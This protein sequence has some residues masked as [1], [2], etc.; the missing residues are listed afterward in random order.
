MSFQVIS[1]VK[2]LLAAQ[3]DA[4]S[5]YFTWILKGFS[6]ITLLPDSLQQHIIKTIAEIYTALLSSE[7]ALIKQK[8]L[9]NFYD[10]SHLTSHAEIIAL[11][12]QNC[13][14]LK[15]DVTNYFQ[16]KIREEANES[17]IEQLCLMHKSNF[18]HA[19]H[20]SNAPEK[21]ELNKGSNFSGQNLSLI[22]TNYQEIIE[23]WKEYSENISKIAQE[24]TSLQKRE[25]QD[26]CTTL[27][28]ILQ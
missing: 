25:I 14:S 8:A 15:Q 3:S 26:F 9:E 6:T 10:F 12:V 7:K 24:L 23:R 27:L 19:C 5:L 11:S 2:K 21:Q 22:V 16:K 17:T 28:N 4:T 18:H 13:P 1:K 20:F